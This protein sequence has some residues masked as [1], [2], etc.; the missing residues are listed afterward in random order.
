MFP[1]RHVGRKVHKITNIVKIA[2]FCK[3]RIPEI[4]NLKMIQ[5]NICSEWYHIYACVQVSEEVI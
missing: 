5:C 3:C 1:T 4:K 2:V